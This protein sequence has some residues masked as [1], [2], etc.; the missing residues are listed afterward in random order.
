M[1][2]RE[3]L[4]EIG[5]GARIL[6]RALKEAGME[7]HFALAMTPTMICELKAADQKLCMYEIDMKDREGDKFVGV[8]VVMLRTENGD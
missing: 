6:T 5:Q 8:P 3:Q 2:T 1:M 7:K 4:Y